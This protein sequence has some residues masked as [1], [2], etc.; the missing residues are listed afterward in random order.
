MYGESMTKNQPAMCKIERDDVIILRGVF[1]K[2][3][4]YAE[5]AYYRSTPLHS[6]SPFLE[7]ILRLAQVGTVIVDEIVCEINT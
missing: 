2:I 6:N 3:L 5:E 7:K 4:E 1:E